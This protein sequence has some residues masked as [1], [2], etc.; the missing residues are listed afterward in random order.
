LHEIKD[1]LG[2]QS[3]ESAR[4]CL[5]LMDRNPLSSTFGCMDRDFWKY[6]TLKEFPSA[7]YQTPMRALATLFHNPVEGNP[8][9]HDEKILEY[10]A[11]SLSYWTSIQHRDG[12]FDEWYL[13]ERSF[14]ATSF[15]SLAAA[16]AYKMLVSHL[17]RK[18]KTNVE[19]SLFLGGT[20][21]ARHHNPW[22]M[23]QNVAALVALLLLSQ[24]LPEKRFKVGLE[25]MKRIVLSGQDREG[26]LLEYGGADIGYCLVSI[27]LL[28]IYLEHS[29]DPEIE[30]ALERLLLFTANFIHPDGTAGGFYGS[31]G[32]QYLMVEGL[33]KRARRNHQAREMLGRIA[34][35]LKDGTTITPGIIDD[36]YFSYFYINSWVEAWI[37]LK[38]IRTSTFSQDFSP[39]SKYFPRSGLFVHRERRYSAF[40]NLKK[41]GAMVAFQN[42]KQLITHAGYEICTKSGERLTS[43]AFLMETDCSKTEN[44]KG[45][46]TY[47]ARG[48]FQKNES[49]LPLVRY[50]VPFKLACR[51]V[52]RFPKLAERF[53]A[54]LRQSMFVKD[55]QAPLV[56]ERAIFFKPKEIVM[57]DKLRCLSRLQFKTV[58]PVQDSILTESPAS[59]IYVTGVPE[60]LD[61]PDSRI[62]E[63][64]NRNG[65]VEIEIRVAFEEQGNAARIC[66]LP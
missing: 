28:A 2:Q 65:I 21:L 26:W 1:I 40:G 43:N 14:C 8:F 50:V 31:R 25:K 10:A 45:R 64:L 30:E 41:A 16:Q 48:F 6:K 60:M 66:V 37:A 35:G 27:D 22:V 47:I 53:G 12:S 58:C 55:D 62:C 7:T 4:R 19:K 13:N 39:N 15:T 44:R 42:Q 9:Y 24:I 51:T 3:I 52:F 33:A 59:N 54:L 49:E 36:K 29:E 56:I 11:G 32:T 17:D 18:T 63:R 5:G 46:T 23:N 34:R 20:W 57:R 38:S 61:W